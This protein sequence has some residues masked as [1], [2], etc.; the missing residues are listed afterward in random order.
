MFKWDA[1]CHSTPQEMSLWAS[2]LKAFLCF[3]TPVVIG[4]FAEEFRII[5]SKK[6]IKIP[7]LVYCRI[8]IYHSNALEELFTLLKSVEIFCSTVNISVVFFCSSVVLWSSCGSEFYR[9]LT[10][11]DFLCSSFSSFHVLLLYKKSSCKQSVNPFLLLML[12]STS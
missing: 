3:L 4:L 5:L 2:S 8:F 9:L 6:Q 1:M 12:F 10:N 11:T 7:S